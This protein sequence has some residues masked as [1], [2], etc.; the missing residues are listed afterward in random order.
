RTAQQQMLGQ[1][2]LAHTAGAQTLF[3]TILPQL[4]RLESLFL[5]DLDAIR[6]EYRDGDGHGQKSR[7]VEQREEQFRLQGSVARGGQRRQNQRRQRPTETH[8]Q[9]APPGVRN[10]NTVKDD[11][12]KPAV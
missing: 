2:H 7:H 8:Q 3:E 5:Q 12:E 10:E 11:E 4:L 9:T 1:V 6:T